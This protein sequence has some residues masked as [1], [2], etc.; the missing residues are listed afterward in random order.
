MEKEYKH[1]DK[2][3]VKIIAFLDAFGDKISTRDIA[4]SLGIHWAT[5]KKSL[6]SLREKGVISRETMGNRTLWELK[7][8]I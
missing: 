1:L 4:N 7:L 2:Y 3:E 8:K 6:E 5:A